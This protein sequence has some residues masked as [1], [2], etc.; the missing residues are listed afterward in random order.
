VDSGTQPRRPPLDM[1]PWPRAW[2]ALLSLGCS[3]AAPPDGAESC[4]AGEESCSGEAPRRGASLLQAKSGRSTQRT[5][6]VTQPDCGSFC[7]AYVS[8]TKGEDHAEND[9]GASPAKPFKSIAYAIKKRKPGQTIHIMEGTY[10]NANPKGPVASLNG[11][12]DLV[13]RNYENERALLSFTGSG[14]LIGGS[15][16]SP[17]R[18]LE[19]FGLEI[20]GPNLDITYEKAI[21]NR[22]LKSGDS[23]FKGR[24]VAIWFGD[25]IHLH[26]LKV[27]NCP[28]SGIRVNK[29]DY[30]LLEDSEVSNNTWWSYAAESGIV[31][32]ESRNIDDSDEYKMIMRR[33]F[34]FDNVN[35]IPYFNKKYA[36]NYSP[37]ASADCSV[38]ACKDQKEGCPWDCRYGK[39]TQDYIIDGQGVYVTRNAKT[40]LKGRMMLSDNVAYRNGINGVVFHR[41]NRGLVS[42][43]TVYDNG[44]VPPAPV[45]SSGRPVPFSLHAEWHQGL[46]IYNDKPG[47]QPFSGIVINNAADVEVKDNVAAARL[48]SDYAFKMQMDSGPMNRVSGSGNKVCRG[49]AQLD[50][51][52]VFT[53]PTSESSG[54]EWEPSM[55][56]SDIPSPWMVK[57]DKTCKDWKDVFANKYGQEK[58]CKNSKTWSQYRYC[59][60]SCFVAEIGYD[61]DACCTLSDDPSPTMAQE[62]EECATSWVAL[63]GL[64][65]LDGDWRRGRWCRRSCF[66]LG[67]GYEGDDCCGIEKER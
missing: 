6:W 37:I 58:L 55:Q 45:D 33:N 34:V 48:D 19:I 63:S 3:W 7:H 30:V 1:H 67:L 8:A 35:K 59:Q 66:F 47:R 38:A 15:P 42:G 52:T 12:S 51:M 64:C 4:A 56:C 40:Y 29:A 24:G 23:H 36:Y 11:V 61:G 2:L 9:Q 54:R 25:H 20:A 57:K 60:H 31:F 14:G 65:N 10:T 21:E 44:V 16:N 18:N 49:K 53:S 43:N 27:Y 50:P 32:A 17:V 62:E 46:N 22:R 13:I 5:P 41:T 39:I 26:H 28:N